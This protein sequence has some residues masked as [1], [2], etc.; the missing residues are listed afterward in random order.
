MCVVNTATV[1]EEEIL[2]IGHLAASS[3]IYLRD[4]QVTASMDE[5]MDETVFGVPTRLKGEGDGCM[6][7][8]HVGPHKYPDIHHYPQKASNWEIW[9][10]R[11]NAAL[12]R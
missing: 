9:R 2:T 11:L 10:H 4:V 6:T 8:A 3:I 5:G 1:K 12:L 7:L